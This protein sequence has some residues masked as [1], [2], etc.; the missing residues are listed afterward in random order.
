MKS[1]YFVAAAIICLAVGTGFSAVKPK[2][3]LTVSKIS[4]STPKPD[5]NGNITILYTVK[6]VGTTPAQASQTKISENSTKNERIITTTAIPSLAPG[7]SYTGRAVYSVVSKKN[8]VFKATADYNNAINE[9]DEANNQ[10]SLSFSF[11]KA[12]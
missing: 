5:K 1:K 2:P 8:Y 10:N 11:G 12:F 9:Y 7:G 3:D 6:N 4:V